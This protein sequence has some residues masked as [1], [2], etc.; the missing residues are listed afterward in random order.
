MKSARQSRLRAA[1]LTSLLLV[2]ACGGG[3]NDSPT[4]PSCTNLSGTWDIAFANSCGFQSS[5]IAVVAQQGCNFSVAIPFQGTVTGTSSQGRADFT[6]AFS[7][8]CSGSAQGTATTSANAVN[9]T[10]SGRAINCCDPVSGSFTLTNR[11]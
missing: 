7:A 5:S 2:A 8:P 3:G 9:G 10:Y 11:R 4:S 6:I 1:C